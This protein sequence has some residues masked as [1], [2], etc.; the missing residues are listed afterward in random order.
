MKN[1][2][3]FSENDD[4]Q[5]RQSLNQKKNLSLCDPNQYSKEESKR[6]KKSPFRVI[7]GKVKVYHNSKPNLIDKG[8]L[9][10]ESELHL[11]SER[12]LLFLK[13]TFLIL[14]LTSLLIVLNRIL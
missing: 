13:F 14:I 7:K 12:M 1:K 10:D 6:Y 9:N 8:Y 11:I 4:I 2:I 3:K 5:E